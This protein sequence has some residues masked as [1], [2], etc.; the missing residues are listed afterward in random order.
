MLWQKID[1]KVIIK[2][3]SNVYIAPKEGENYLNKSFG[4][5]EE[6]D[7]ALEEIRQI[8]ENIKTENLDKI[9]KIHKFPF[10][11]CTKVI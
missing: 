2:K 10:H 1:K 5:K 9:H 11:I 4:S 3:T 7:N 8:V 6:I